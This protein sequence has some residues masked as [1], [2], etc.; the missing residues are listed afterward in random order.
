[1]SRIMIIDDANDGDADMLHYRENL[2]QGIVVLHFRNGVA[3]IKHLKS[4]IDKIDLILL[5]QNFNYGNPR[6]VQ[7]VKSKSEGFAVVDFN[8]IQFNS[9]PKA[10]VLITR[11]GYTDAQVVQQQGIII[12]AA[13]KKEV[14]RVP[15]VIFCCTKGEVL[16]AEDVTEDE[17]VDYITKDEFK[18]A[19]SR[20][21]SKKLPTAPV[22]LEEMVQEIA[23]EKGLDI[24]KTA[25]A[26]IVLKCGETGGDVRQY[27]SDICT[28]LKHK[29]IPGDFFT[30]K[31]VR[32]A[33]DKINISERMAGTIV[34]KRFILMVK[35][36]FS[37]LNADGFVFMEKI[38]D[39]CDSLLSELEKPDPSFKDLVTQCGLIVE[40]YS[41]S[42]STIENQ[43]VYEVFHS[44]TPR[45]AYADLGKGIWD[46]RINVTHY[47]ANYP[48]KIGIKVIED[49]LKF[50][51][52]CY[53][54]EK[55]RAKK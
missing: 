11:K 35:D 28:E 33:V 38:S 18:K 32:R 7:G 25:K 36:K 16:I 41:K 46:K 8:N 45:F 6:A 15:P 37:D 34:N 19:L 20:I 24:D 44:L 27:A 40:M 17:T 12:L 29:A 50:L 21:L 31:D 47:G 26:F 53:T 54:W 10:Q 42:V 2:P 22:S 43:S 48:R 4:K 51:E 39:E 52:G 55:S 30:I 3:A 1:M 9:D 23:L 14:H 13:L 49:T 5:D